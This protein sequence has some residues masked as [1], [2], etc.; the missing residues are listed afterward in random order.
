VMLVR[1]REAT[2]R[3]EQDREELQHE[4]DQLAK[5]VERFELNAATIIAE[6]KAERDQLEAKLDKRN[7]LLNE[8]IRRADA[9]ASD[10]FDA[11]QERDQLKAEREDL[12]DELD[13][14]KAERDQLKTEL[15]A[16]KAE[17]DSLQ[18]F[19]ALSDHYHEEL[20]AV[21]AELRCAQ[22]EIFDLKG[23]IEDL[24]AERSELLQR[25]SKR[26]REEQCFELAKQAIDRAATDF[27]SGLSVW[28]EQHKMWIA[29]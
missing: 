5:T 27:I 6:L 2:K 1:E 22:S 12:D 24:E 23:E 9:S 19:D 29:L 13:A 3:A 28:R 15:D 4:R 26:T 7:E 18:G 21:E 16:V 25:L 17:R 14:V 11:M 20:Q 8:Q 10:A